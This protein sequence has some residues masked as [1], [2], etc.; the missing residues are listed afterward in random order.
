[1]S[2]ILRPDIRSNDARPCGMLDGPPAHPGPRSHDQ[3]VPR[4]CFGRSCTSRRR[5]TTGQTWNERW[6]I[7]WQRIGF[8]HLRCRVIRVDLPPIQGRVVP[9]IPIRRREPRRRVNVRLLPGS[10]IPIHWQ[11]PI[12]CGEFDN[13]STFARTA[14][15]RFGV[16]ITGISF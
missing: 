11:H 8:C 2:P 16:R 1:M 6:K 4:P 15:A 5:S 14:Y 7:R 12:R 3:R 13:V 10:A 9:L